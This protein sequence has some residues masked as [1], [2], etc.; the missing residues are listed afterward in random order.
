MHVVSP[1]SRPTSFNPARR[2][3]CSSKGTIHPQETGYW[4]SHTGFLTRTQAIGGR[5]S[6]TSPVQG[7]RQ[8]L[9]PQH[10]TEEALEVHPIPAQDTRLQSAAAWACLTTALAEHETEHA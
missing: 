5:F 7:S 1:R 3:P 6:S 9:P 2:F 10:R 8:P 4:R